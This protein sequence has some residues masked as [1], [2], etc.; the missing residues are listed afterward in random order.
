MALID[1]I[2]A[3]EILDSRGNP[4]VEVEVLLTDGSVGRAA[5][6]SGASTGEFEAVERRDGDKGRY[7][8]KGVQDAV[9]AVDEIADELEGAFAED[10]RAVDYAMLDLDGTPNKGKVGANAILGVSMAVAVAA[11]QSAELPL[12]KYLGGPNAHVLPVPMMNI[13]NGGA[14]ADSNVDIQEFMIAPIGAP[15]FKEALRWGAEVYHAL[16]KVLQ[17]KGLGT[18]LGDEGGFAPNLESNRAALDLIAEAVQAAG[19]TLG[20]DIALALDVASSEFCENGRYTFEGEQR[21]AEQMAAYYTELVDNYPIV[22]IEDPLDEND[23]E[24]WQLLTESLG[25]RVQLVGDDLFVT[26]VERLQRGIDEKAGNALLVKVNQI[27]SMTETFDAISLAQRH[28]FHCMISH[29][30]GETEDTFIADLAVATNAG[31]IK[32]GAPARSDRVAK[33]NQLLRIEEELGDAAVYAGRTAFPRFQ[34]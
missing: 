18:G 24:G 5:V 8:G 14:H 6:P 11:A 21:S 10:Q 34:G 31:Q 29:R 20:E 33:Y 1:A 17:D 9:A 3:R 25:G 28:M 16:K 12:F 26:N 7:L 22:S 32:T 2:Q 15:T 27:G 4:T 23:W 13:L 19:Y 30:S